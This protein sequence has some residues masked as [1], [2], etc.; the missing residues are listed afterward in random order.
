MG[1]KSKN[2]T[3]MK[4]PSTHPSQ[5]KPLK[6]HSTTG[7]DR[8]ICGQI[9]YENN[10][11]KLQSLGQARGWPISL[12]FNPMVTYTVA[13]KEKLLDLV[14]YEDYLCDC[15]VWNDFLDSINCKIHELGRTDTV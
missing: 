7:Q 14:H 4:P 12:E 6:P 5:S 11:M 2:V 3:N 10:V 13:L 8:E 1:K 15:M 9:S